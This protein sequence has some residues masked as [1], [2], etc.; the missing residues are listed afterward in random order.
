M[1]LAH[2]AGKPAPALTWNL[3]LAEMGPGSQ[4][5]EQLILRKGWSR[6]H[7]S[8]PQREPPPWAEDCPRPHPEGPFEPVGPL[9]PWVSSNPEV[10]AGCLP[11]LCPPLNNH[12][13]VT[14]TGTAKGTCC[15]VSQALQ[16]RPRKGPALRFPAVPRTQPG[17]G[18]YRGIDGHLHC[19]VST[20]ASDRE[21]VPGGFVHLKASGHPVGGPAAMARGPAPGG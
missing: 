13:A 17:S 20:P 18:F 11:L 6:P 5:Q 9:A 7:S 16:G 21:A 1:P 15:P 12:V 4:G 3:K 8:A 10:P 19:S 2:R 14:A